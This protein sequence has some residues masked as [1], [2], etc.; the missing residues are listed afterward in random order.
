MS[1]APII[2]TNSSLLVGEQTCQRFTLS[3]IQLAT[4]N[5]DETLVIG[6]GGFGNVYKC[7]V[8]KI[9]CGSEVAVKRL[10]TMSKQG[11]HEFE[12]EVKVLSKL[13]HA[14][15]VSLVGYCIEGQE[16]ALVYEFMPN[17]TLKDHLRKADCALS[18]SQRLKI[19]IGAARGLHYLH[20]GTSTQHGVIHRDV[21]TSN[22]LLD[23]KFAAKISDFGL[24]KVGPIDQ[25]RTYVITNVKGTFGYFDPCYFYTGKLN[26]KSDVYAFGV[27]LF[28]VLS[29][30]QAVDST[31]DEE[32]QGLAPWAQRQIKEGKLDQI[33]DP[34]LMGQI[35]RKCLKKFVK[36]ACHCL[37]DKQKERPT[38]D[39]V[40]FRL[41]C[42]LSKERENKDSIVYKLRAFFTA[43]VD[44]MLD[45]EVGK[46]SVIPG[47]AVGSNSIMSGVAPGNES[48][49]SGVVVGRNSVMLGGAVRSKCMM[50]GVVVGSKSV[51]PGV[52]VGSNSVMSGVAVGSESVMS[53]VAVGRKSK[54]LAF[55][56]RRSKSVMSGVTVGSK[57]VMPDVAVGS[58]SVMS[59]AAVG[60]E[61]VMSGVAVGRKSK[62]LAFAVRGSK[63]VM[64]GVAVGS[65]SM[66]PNVAVGSNSVMSGVAT[67]SESVM[68]DVAVGSKSVMPGVAVGSNSV[69]SGVAVG[70]ESVMSGVAV[71]RK[72]KALAFAVRGSKSVMSGVA[73]GSKSVNQ[74]GKVVS[75]Y[76]FSAHHI[77]NFTTG[78]IRTFTYDELVSAT[79]D[80]KDMEHSP[81]SYKSV[82]KGWV[83]EKSYAPTECGVGLAIYVRKEILTWKLNL[84][85]L[86]FSHPNIT[87]LLGYC[88]SNVT[89]FW[90]YE[91]FP[92]I[93]LDDLLFKDPDTTTLS[94]AARLKIAQGAA[95]GLS[96]FHRRNRPAYNSFDGNHILVDR[97]FNARLLDYEIDNLLAP[98]GC[99]TFERNK[100][101]GIFG[102]VPGDET[103]VQSEIYDFGV[104]LLK[105][106]TGMKKYDERIPLQQKNL[107]E[108]AT[109]LLA[110][111]VNLRM[112]MDPQLQHNDHPPKGAFEL[113]Q[114]VSKC[115]QPTRDKNLSIEEISQVFKELIS[116]LANESEV[117]SCITWEKRLMANDTF[118]LVKAK[119]YNEPTGFRSGVGSTLGDPSME[120]RTV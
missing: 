31:L 22:I 5:F 43:T 104:V 113:A 80:F 117:A 78:S 3:E 62:A 97:D 9:G 59:G 114:L 109:P 111:K 34:K 76:E 36:I 61:S 28:E 72:S 27:V 105:M 45:R 8:S 96:F 40:I 26:R 39:E 46:K 107:M 91:L 58:N 25:T 115:L 10:R 100:S 44:I 98:P 103:G 42:I 11:A 38:M 81:T 60:S 21:K 77:Q 93:C 14:N 56:V 94:W 75:K 18:W 74:D 51:M 48:V 86:E 69:M 57:S 89:M 33:I 71:G 13:R 32:P 63:S 1:D 17:G 64:S 24:A 66:M 67:G 49:M 12:A 102:R 15:L 29:G 16:M 84:K 79:S 7:D 112:I 92:G 47:V 68:S 35:S 73:V 116:K 55:A 88:L 20:T 90:V 4:N 23:A 19:C 120:L 83:D 52:A 108:W 6:S 54:A 101:D 53:G 99:S 41:E 82:Y 65:K 95:Q 2:D 50:S 70:S 30:K 110:N 119:Y 37:R 85:L 106:L 87:R 118:G